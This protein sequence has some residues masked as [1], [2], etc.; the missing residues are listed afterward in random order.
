MYSF[1]YDAIALTNQLSKRP[2]EYINQAITKP[3]GYIGINGAFRFF[4]D[5]TNQHSLDIV[6]IRSSGNVVVDAAPKSFNTDTDIEKLPTIDV[7]SVISAPK[8]FGK[9]KQSAEISIFGGLIP[10]EETFSE[11]ITNF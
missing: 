4:E 2:S 6:E 9:N 11:S 5:G 7:S 1:A 8:I 10:S 3:E